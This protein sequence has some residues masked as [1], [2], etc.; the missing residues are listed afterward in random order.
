MPQCIG[1]QFYDRSTAQTEDKLVRWGKCRRTGPIVHPVSAKAYMVEGIWPQVRD[2]DWCG[3]WVSSNRRIDSDS[4]ATEAMSSL[5]AQSGSPVARPSTV[6]APF[7]PAQAASDPLR[8]LAPNVSMTP[9]ATVGPL[10]GAISA[11]GSPLG[12]D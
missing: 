4:V 1:C 6:L 2:D 12:S 7:P 11:N 8:P 3:E 9:T 5:L 10:S